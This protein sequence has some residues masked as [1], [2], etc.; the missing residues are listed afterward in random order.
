M[1]RPSFPTSLA[2]FQ[3][4]FSTEEACAAFLAQSRWPDGFICPRCG[5]KEAFGLP[6]RGLYQCK[7][8]Q[9]QASVTAGTVMH[10]TRT[11]L[12]QWFRAVYLLTTLT[13]GISALQLRRQLGLVSYVDFGT[14]LVEISLKENSRS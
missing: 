8:C 4:R 5:G 13:P 3:M 11:P 1:S 9:Y 7:L 12:V 10:A 6:R 2:E 14:F